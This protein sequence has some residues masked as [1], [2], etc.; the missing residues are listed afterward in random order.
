MDKRIGAQYYTIRDYIGTINDFETSCKKISDIGYKAVQISGTPLAASDMRKVL[1]EYGLEV[2]TTHR[3]FEDFIKNPEEIMEYN[4]ILGSD[5]CGVGAMPGE[6]R[7][8]ADDLSRFIEQANRI[9]GLFKKENMFF[10]YHNHNFEFAKV[11]GKLIFDR[12]VEE[13]D[14]ETFNFIFDTYWCQAG[15]KNP[16]K[17]I[18]KLGKRAMALHFK[19][20][21]IQQDDVCS[22]PLMAEIGEGNLDWDDIITAAEKAGSRWAL[23]EQ[24][25]CSGDPFASLKM[26]YDYLSAKGFF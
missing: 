2:Y 8:T 18:E 24:D 20:Y 19:D 13:T 25:I 6:Y 4:R 1:D 23:V 22:Q 17:I 7:K 9:C 21:A 14:P 11:D 5:L 10:G 16:A 26:S 3:S 15:G 12:L